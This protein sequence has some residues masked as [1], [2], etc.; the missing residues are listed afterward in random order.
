MLKKAL[1]IFGFAVIFS[2]EAFAQPC[3]STELIA[4]A[5]KYDGSNVTYQGEVVGEVMRRGNF[6]WVNVHDGSNAIGLWVPAQ[7]TREIVYAGSYKAKGDVVEVSGIFRRACPEHGGD[8]DIHVY[9][10]RKIDSGRLVAEKINTA[11]VFQSLVLLGVLVALW[12]LT[13]FLRK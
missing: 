3:S 13:L 12:I 5:K 6:S 7:L 1:F 11:K 8:L 2:S 10:L 4:N 9:S